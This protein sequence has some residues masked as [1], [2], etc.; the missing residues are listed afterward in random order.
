MKVTLEQLKKIIEEEM[1]AEELEE[2]NTRPLYAAG[3]QAKT[4]KMDQKEIER[5]QAMDQKTRPIAGVSA[6]GFVVSR[7][8]VNESLLKKLI[9]EELEEKKFFKILP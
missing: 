3:A 1:A 7:P 4:R 6:G 8:K 5:H 9:R 2:A